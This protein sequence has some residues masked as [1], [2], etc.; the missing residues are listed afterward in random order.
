MK[1]V[2]KP[3]AVRRKYY[4]E[5]TYRNVE[6]FDDAARAHKKFDEL[7]ALSIRDWVQVVDLRNGEVIADSREK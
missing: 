6:F 3:Y 1:Y 7:R 5:R 2:T 4:N